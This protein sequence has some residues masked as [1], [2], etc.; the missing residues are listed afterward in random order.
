V[1]GGGW[2][3]GVR[4]RVYDL[5]GARKGDGRLWF[6]DFDLRGRGGI[7]PK[8]VR[9]RGKG[10]G[11]FLMDVGGIRSELGSN[12]TGLRERKRF[13]WARSFIELLLLGNLGGDGNEGG[14]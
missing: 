9:G 5:G 6:G 8:K 2:D 4:P 1:L 11:S 7:V 10:S 13:E 12:E 3:D 14:A